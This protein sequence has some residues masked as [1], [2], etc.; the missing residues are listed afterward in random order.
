MLE[1]RE[2]DIG[3]GEQAS[4]PSIYGGPPTHHHPAH[5]HGE[6]G[7]GGGHTRAGGALGGSGGEGGTGCKGWR[8]AKG[9]QYLIVF[10]Y[11]LVSFL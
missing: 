11:N 3:G 4:S 10:V 1:W 6:G 8:R 2:L 9:L 7:R 5:V